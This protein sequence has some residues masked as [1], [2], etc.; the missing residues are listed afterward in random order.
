MATTAIA[1]KL[2]ATRDDAAILFCRRP[3][4]LACS[5]LGGPPLDWIVAPSCNNWF[6]VGLMTVAKTMSATIAAIAPMPY[7]TPGAEPAHVPE[8][9]LMSRQYIPS[10][11]KIVSSPA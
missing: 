5:E 2:A 3:S 9:I 7:V 8:L 11:D 4:V 1:R 10:P 6:P